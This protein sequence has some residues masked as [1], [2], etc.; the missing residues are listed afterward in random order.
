MEK[1]SHCHKISTYSLCIPPFLTADDTAFTAV[2]RAEISAVKSPVALGCF[3]CSSSRNLVKV[4]G[5]VSIG[6]P[7]ILAVG[8]CRVYVYYYTG[9]VFKPVI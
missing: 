6:W 4:T 2:C 9:F 1:I 3:L 7:D 8:D 5:Q